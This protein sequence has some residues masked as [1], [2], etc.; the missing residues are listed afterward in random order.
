MIKQNNLN[1]KCEWISIWCGGF[2][3]D[4]CKYVNLS[5]I[6]IFFCLLV[7]FSPHTLR[8]GLIKLWQTR[9]SK[10][11]MYVCMCVFVGAC[12]CLHAHTCT[13]VSLSVCKEVLIRQKRGGTVNPKSEHTHLRDPRVPCDD[14]QASFHWRC[15]TGDGLG[16]S[17]P[18][19]PLWLHVSQLLH[20]APLSTTKEGPMWVCLC[21]CVL[22]W[23]GVH[24]MGA[25]DLLS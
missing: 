11:Y 1:K 3:L 25:L 8:Q 18:K 6:C 15:R 16:P 14:W 22:G 19:G 5:F 4:V 2:F 17:R 23:C 12:V 9:S 20:H 13:H 21:V 24:G 7:S 10:P